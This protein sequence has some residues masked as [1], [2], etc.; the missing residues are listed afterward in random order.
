MDLLIDARGQWFYQGGS[1]QR[2]DLV[3]LLSTV[4]VY[5]DG[6]YFLLSPA[7]R[8]RI[9]VED[10]PFLATDFEV[11][12]TGD[13]QQVIFDTNVGFKAP[14]DEHH[15]LRMRA[16]PGSTVEVPYV[17]VR[18]GIEARLARSVFYRLVELGEERQCADGRRFGIAS[19][20]RFFPL[21]PT[22]R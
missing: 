22:E 21:G 7:E 3:R 11:A 19:G 12:D 5:Q 15:P 13:G 20:G 6:E 16:A 4:L 10:V 2:Q 18:D 14:L 8:L 1:F 9:R 17:E